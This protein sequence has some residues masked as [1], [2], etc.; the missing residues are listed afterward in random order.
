MDKIYIL[1]SFSYLFSEKTVSPEYIYITQNKLIEINKVLFIDSGCLL[2]KLY[3]YNKLPK[4]KYGIAVNDV[5]MQKGNSYFI[6]D[7]N[8]P[9]SPKNSAIQIIQPDFFEIEF[10]I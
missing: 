3:L 7:I 5:E 4:Q 6:D 9:I 10:I 2:S 1:Y 8:N